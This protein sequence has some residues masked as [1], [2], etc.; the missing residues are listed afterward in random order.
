MTSMPLVV[1]LGT[2]DIGKA[3]TCSTTHTAPQY[4]ITHYFLPFTITKYISI[5]A[6]FMVMYKHDEF[7]TYKKIISQK[8]LIS[9]DKI[10]FTRHTTLMH[11]SCNTVQCYKTGKTQNKFKQYMQTEHHTWQ[12]IDSE[13]SSVSQVPHATVIIQ[14]TVWQCKIKP[15]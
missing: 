6:H 15:N 2:T 5:K 7:L 11:S 8:N 13:E 12:H 14:T 9:D 4:L 1:T 3:A 10:S